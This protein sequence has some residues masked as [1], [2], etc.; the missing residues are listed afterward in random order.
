M[1]K[2]RYKSMCQT[3]TTSQKHLRFNK[4]EPELV[5]AFSE[6][7][8]VQCKNISHESR[9][10]K[11]LIIECVVATAKFSST[12]ISPFNIDGKVLDILLIS[13]SPICPVNC[14]ILC[15]FFQCV[16]HRVV[17]VARLKSLKQSICR[18]YCVSQHYLH[19]LII[20]SGHA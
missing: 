1:L 20:S 13:F 5:R 16:G 4:I 3:G 17:V 12:S 11:S 14:L 9:H 2:W 19:P 18:G 10:N 7:I 8:E 6:S 15:Y